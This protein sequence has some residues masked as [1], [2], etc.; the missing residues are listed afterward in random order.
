MGNHY[1]DPADHNFHGEMFKRHW[2]YGVYD[3]RVIFYEEMLTLAYMQSKPDTCYPIATAEAVAVAGYYPTQSCIRYSSARD[4]VTVSLE[5]FV[6]RAAT[7]PGP[8]REVAE[9]RAVGSGRGW[10]ATGRRWWA[11]DFPRS[12]RGARASPFGPIAD[13]R[14]RPLFGGIYFRSTTGGARSPSC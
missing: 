4:E 1:I 2:V 13:L 10:S 3:G 14:E 5:G 12:N 11:R 9:R 7:A 8:L 6:S